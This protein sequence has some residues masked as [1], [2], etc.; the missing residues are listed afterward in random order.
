M[1][2]VL[3][4]SLSSL[5]SPMRVNVLILESRR[6][7]NPFLLVAMAHSPSGRHAGLRSTVSTADCVPNYF[8]VFSIL[9][10]FSNSFLQNKKLKILSSIDF[11]KFTNSTSRPFNQTRD[12]STRLSHCWSFG[13]TWDFHGYILL[14]DKIRNKHTIKLKFFFFLSEFNHFN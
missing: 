12:G 2:F 9:P 6:S 4:I 5:I 13:E 3:F 7:R 10:Q 8:T 14:R 1:F 11:N